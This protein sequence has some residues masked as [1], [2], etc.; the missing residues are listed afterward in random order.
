RLG[1]AAALM[2]VQLKPAELTELVRTA[3]CAPV[4]IAGDAYAGALAQALSGPVIRG[5]GLHD[6]VPDLKVEGGEPDAALVIFTSGT[7]GLPKA[8]PISQG[9][10]SRRTLSYAPPF[11]PDARPAVSMMC[12]PI[13]HVGGSLEVLGSLFSGST[14]VIQPRFR[15]EE[16]LRLVQR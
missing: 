4:G 16:W 10:L 11:K 5:G 3:G 9:V 14:V 13:F 15:A 7:T 2:N 8:V 1:A 6:P 12:V